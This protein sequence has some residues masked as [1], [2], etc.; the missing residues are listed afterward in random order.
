MK[1]L[2]KR[3]AWMGA[4]VVLL[5]LIWRVVQ[6]DV[7]ASVQEESF[8]ERA[9]TLVVTFPPGGGTD[10][11][12]RKLGAELEQRWRQPVVIENR[13][14]ASGNIGSRHVADAKAD[15]YT[16]LMVNSSFA[17]NPGVY[18]QL[19]FDPKMTSRQSSMWR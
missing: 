15:G 10:L 6:L 8:P 14:G 16:L 11:L 5:L 7:Q 12:A 3:F 1:T 4:G 9:V 18:R 13:P 17:I 2:M 19:G